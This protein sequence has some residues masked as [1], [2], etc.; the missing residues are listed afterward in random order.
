MAKDDTSRDAPR[1]AKIAA[2]AF[3]SVFF[4]LIFAVMLYALLAG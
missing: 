4:L 3:A 1:E 2:A